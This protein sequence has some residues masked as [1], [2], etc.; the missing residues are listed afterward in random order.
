VAPASRKA[1]ADWTPF[2]PFESL[3]KQE[4]EYDAVRARVCACAFVCVPRQRWRDGAGGTR[5]P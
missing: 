2:D 4:Q 5:L 1:P 3:S